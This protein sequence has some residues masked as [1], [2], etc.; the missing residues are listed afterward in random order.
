MD[1][2]ND[3]GT[4][5]TLYGIEQYEKYPTTLEDHFG[6]SQRA[7]VL[8]QLRVRCTAMA[9]GNANAG[10]SAWYLSM[11][12]HKEAWGRLG[13]YGYDLQDQCGA[14]NVFSYR[15]DE[16]AIDELRGP[17]YPNY[18]MNVGHQ[19]GYAGIA[20]AAHAARGDAFACKPAD[21]GMLRRQEPAVRL[22]Q[23]QEGVRPWRTPRVHACRR[24]S[25][26]IPAK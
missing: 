24:E 15:S 4:E 9:T 12:L 20:G 3:I 7:T 17:N 23:A 1:V 10:L 22:H 14:T 11:L 5:V 8:P 2:V 16:G 21:Q 26:I 25:L 19:G 18:A 13:F 6:G